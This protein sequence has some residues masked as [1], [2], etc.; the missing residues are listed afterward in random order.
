[1]LALTR[2]AGQSIIIGDVVEITIVEVRG[3]QVRLGITAPK[4]VSVYRKEIYDEIKAENKAAIG[5][6]GISL[7]RVE[8]ALTEAVKERTKR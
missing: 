2:K 5:I 1:M 7:E 3:D 8:K 4:E 6:S